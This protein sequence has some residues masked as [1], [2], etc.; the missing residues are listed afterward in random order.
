MSE[1]TQQV[2]ETTQELEKIAKMSHFDMCALWR[3]APAGHPYFDARLPY[4]QVFR[5]RLF[6]EFGGFTPE[7]SKAIGWE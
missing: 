6:G 4:H 2:S 5:D 7:I 1:T 3:R